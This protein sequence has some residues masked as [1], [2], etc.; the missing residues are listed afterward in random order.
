MY[1]EDTFRSSSPVLKITGSYDSISGYT[2]WIHRT[3]S[4]NRRFRTATPIFFTLRALAF[5]ATCYHQ[6]SPAV[7]NFLPISSRVDGLV[8]NARNSQAAQ[9]MEALKAGHCSHCRNHDLL[10]IVTGIPDYVRGSIA[11]RRR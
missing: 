11:N 10:I 5:C 7:L 1:R 6:F 9:D 8:F 2:G 3:R 4:S